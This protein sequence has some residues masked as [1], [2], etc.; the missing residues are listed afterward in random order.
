LNETERA[1]IVA[2]NIEL[3]DGALFRRYGHFA[4]KLIRGERFTATT[5]DGMVSQFETGISGSRTTL[6]APQVAQT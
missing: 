2:E 5:I 1:A 3:R 4:G 6:G